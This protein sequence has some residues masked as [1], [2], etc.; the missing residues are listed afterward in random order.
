MIYSEFKGKWLN[1]LIK[2]ISPMNEKNIYLSNDSS[3]FSF[4]G[5]WCILSSWKYWQPFAAVLSGKTSLYLCVYSLLFYILMAKDFLLLASMR[6]G[7]DQRLN[8]MN[9]H[10]FL[11]LISINDFQIFLIFLIKLIFMGLDIFDIEF[12]NSLFLLNL[13]MS[14]NKMR[15]DN[16]GFLKTVH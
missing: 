8:R 14:L 5:F 7:L 15:L 6:K 11:F 9:L 16:Y 4:I 10:E 13:L 12:L 3:F 2:D 1:L